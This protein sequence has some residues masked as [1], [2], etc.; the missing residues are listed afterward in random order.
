M[1]TG[2]HMIS[3]TYRRSTE[4]T[5]IG[6]EVLD[7]VIEPVFEDT[8]PQE[9]VDVECLDRMIGNSDMMIWECQGSMTTVM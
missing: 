9:A 6:H 5:F 2:Q 8:F 7:A 3:A 4:D 1:S